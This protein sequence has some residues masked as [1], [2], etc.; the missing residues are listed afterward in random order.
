MWAFETGIGYK[1]I[2]YPDLSFISDYFFGSVVISGN[3]HGFKSCL[4]IRIEPEKGEKQFAGIAA[5]KCTVFDPVFDGTFSY[6]AL[7]AA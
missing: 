2:D 6:A 7:V 5:A 3:S 4:D 1:L